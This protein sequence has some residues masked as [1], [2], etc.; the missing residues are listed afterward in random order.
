MSKHKIYKFKHKYW[1]VLC[2]VGLWPLCL[3]R[4]NLN[5][6]GI[7]FHIMCHCV[8]YIFYTVSVIVINLFLTLRAV[9]WIKDDILDIFEYLIMY[10]LEPHLLCIH[11]SRNFPLESTEFGGVHCTYMR[12]MGPL[13]DSTRP[14]GGQIVYNC[15]A[16]VVAR[17]ILFIIS[18][19]SGTNTPK[20]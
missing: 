6:C 4:D 20:Y 15:A 18:I 19:S 14:W 12:V 2:N 1:T 11:A 5:K 10:V 8:I 16:N 7:F 17:F 13:Q 3:N 9:W